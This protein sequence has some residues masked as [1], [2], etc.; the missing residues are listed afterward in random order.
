MGCDVLDVAYPTGRVPG[1]AQG[2]SVLGRLSCDSE[3][4]AQ[5]LENFRRLIDEELGRAKRAREHAKRQQPGR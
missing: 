4:V 1:A 5:P 3:S 2:L